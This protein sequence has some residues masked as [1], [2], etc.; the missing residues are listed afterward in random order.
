MSGQK[1]DGA[2]A[3]VIRRDQV[4]LHKRRDF[5]VWALPGGGIEPGEAPDVAA[6]R[7]V[8]EETGYD[9]AIDRLLGKY[10]RPQIPKGYSAV[11][12]GR[13]IGGEAMQQ[14]PETRAVKWF[15]LNS[16]PIG[17]VRTHRVYIQDAVSASEEIIKRT[18]HL[19]P[20][21]VF[22]IRF[23]RWLRDTLKSRSS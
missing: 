3:V 19:S 23:L 18:I 21:E 7:E 11:F 14:G 6:V 2:T 10:N 15:P 4:L 16:L 17:L 20:L 1:F 12:L 5:R 8:R 22:L 9:I 13:V